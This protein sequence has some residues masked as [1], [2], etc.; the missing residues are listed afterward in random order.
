M[1]VNWLISYY[2][3]NL[4]II[5]GK[6]SATLQR[7]KSNR[8]MNKPAR[9]VILLHILA[10]YCFIVGFYNSGGAF[11]STSLLKGRAVNEKGYFSLA[12]V[13][14]LSHTTNENVA[15]ALNNLQQ[16]FSNSHQ[17]CIWTSLQTA[18]QFLVSIPFGYIYR[19][20]DIVVNLQSTDIIF[21]FHYFL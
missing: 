10:L 17:N 11:S 18:E 19:S 1:W 5:R 13:N 15:K 21:P 3:L 12:S 14:L 2:L 7:Y 8:S 9:V 20:G 4:H 6:S 16:V